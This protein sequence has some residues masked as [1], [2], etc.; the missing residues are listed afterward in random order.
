MLNRIWLAG[1]SSGLVLGWIY[2]WA[3]PS[4]CGTALGT[5]PILFAWLVVAKVLGSTFADQHK[6]PPIAIAA[7]AHGLLLC[8]LCWVIDRVIRRFVADEATVR[9]LGFAFLVTL[10]AGVLF[11]V[12]P[13]QDCP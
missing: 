4:G 7:F 3:G 9:L 1:F 6:W 13:L 2:G 10:Y 11:F 12:W 8:F 5:M